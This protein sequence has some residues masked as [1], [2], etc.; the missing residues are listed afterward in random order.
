MYGCVPVCPIKLKSTPRKAVPTVN[1]LDPNCITDT[2]DP[3]ANR[4]IITQQPPN[5]KVA[6]VHKRPKR[7][8]VCVYT[9]G[10]VVIRTDVGI[11]ATLPGHSCVRRLIAPPPQAGAAAQIPVVTK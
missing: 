1:I 9:L 3:N 10:R 4:I 8:C 11:T 2:V 7:V 6:A 5:E